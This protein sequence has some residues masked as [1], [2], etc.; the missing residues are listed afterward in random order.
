MTWTTSI[1]AHPS[2]D[3]RSL[4]Q[5][6]ETSTSPTA[7]TVV[8][9]ESAVRFL[10]AQGA[11]D[12]LTI[13]EALHAAV[14]EAEEVTNRT[15]RQSVTRTIYFRGW[16][17]DLIIP[18]APLSSVTSVKY[19]NYADTLTLLASSTYNVQA[20]TRG[21][22]RIS[23]ESDY[24]FPNLN[25]DRS[26]PVQVICVTGYGSEDQIPALAKTAIRLLCEANYDGAPEK[27][28]E[29]HKILRP[30]VNRA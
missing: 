23:W 3:G 14:N 27:R 17:R 28:L 16:S 12:D 6:I 25:E 18:L 13:L 2:G 5:R 20:S 30:L 15:L 29:A 26:D 24:T 21:P 22:G 4:L 19:Y 11:R 9:F 7:D 1:S 8:S 10:K